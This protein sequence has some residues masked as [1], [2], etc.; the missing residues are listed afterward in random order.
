[1]QPAKE[2]SPELG[3]VLDSVSRLGFEEKRRVWQTLDREIGRAEEERWENDP[4][5]QAEIRAARAAYADGDYVTLGEY[6]ARDAKSK[7]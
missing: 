7:A 4:S 1:M 3:A 5:V 6:L 2:M